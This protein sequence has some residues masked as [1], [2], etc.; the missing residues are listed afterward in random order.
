MWIKISEMFDNIE[1]G[2]MWE[3]LIIHGVQSPN[4]LISVLESSTE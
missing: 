4:S 1:L 2:M 3:M